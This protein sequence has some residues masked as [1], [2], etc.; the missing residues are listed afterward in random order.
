MKKLLSLILAIC[1]LLSVAPT[2]LSEETQPEEEVAVT[3]AA[4]EADADTNDPAEA[5]DPEPAPAPAEVKEEE[6]A[7]P[8]PAPAEVKEEEDADAGTERDKRRAADGELP[9]AGAGRE[10]AESR[11]SGG[12]QGSPDPG[13]RAY[14]AVRPRRG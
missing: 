13:I 5:P 10:N 3:A 14:R 1:L 4:P 11:R 8:A 7:E 6:A 9:L 2:T 12:I